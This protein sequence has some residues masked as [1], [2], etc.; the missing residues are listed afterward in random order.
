MAWRDTYTYKGYLYVD[1]PAVVFAAR[2]NQASFTFPLV[3]LTYDGVATGAIA[4]ALPG[5]TLLVGS[6]A[7]ADDLGRVR[8]RKAGSATKIYIGEASQGTLDGEMNPTDDAYL[9]VIAERRVWAVEPYINP[10]TK[11]Y[12]KDYEIPVIDGGRNY[13]QYPGPLA[14]GG[15]DRIGVISSGASY[16]F[17]FNSGYSMAVSSGSTLSGVT[18]DVGDGT[19]VAGDNAT[20]AVI[21]AD[22]PKGRRYV[23][24]TATDSNGHTHTHYILTVVLDPTDANWT[25]IY[26][27][28]IKERRLS[29][30]GPTLTVTVYESLLPATYPEGASVFYWENEAYDG[31]AGSLAG[32][33]TCEH[34]KFRGWINSEA[35]NPV[36]TPNGVVPA[37]ELRCVSTIERMRRIN[38]LPQRVEDNA[39][40]TKWW[41]LTGPTHFGFLYYL[42]RWHSTVLEVAPPSF[43]NAD[44]DY[45]SMAKTTASNLY[46]QIAEFAKASRH[47]LTCDQRGILYWADYQ[48]LIPVASRTA[49]VIET[50]TADD[51]Y[52]VS[53]ERDRPPEVYWLD[54]KGIT[55]LDNNPV[56]CISPGSA[57]GQGA[58]RVE[59]AGQYVA[60]QTELNVTTGHEY[61]RINSPWL[62][63]RVKVVHPGDIGID[64]AYQF[65]VQLTLPA[66]TNTR[67]YSFTNQRCQV[68]EVTIRQPSDGRN[69]K[70]V[71]IALI[72]ETVGTPAQTVVPETGAV[73]PS[74]TPPSSY[75]PIT[76]YNP[77]GGI[78]SLY[79]HKGVKKIAG[80]NTDGYVYITNDFGAVN[81]VWTRYDLGL[82][83]NSHGLKL[84]DFVV[85][86]FSP[87]YRGTGS[88]ING[89]IAGAKVIA[90]IDDIFGART[91]TTQFNFPTEIPA[92]PYPGPDWRTIDASFGFQNWAMC[93]TRYD[94]GAGGKQG[95]YLAYTT[96]GTNWQTEQH[97]G[98]YTENPGANGADTGLYISSKTAGRAYA[99]G[100]YAAGG[101]GGMFRPTKGYVTTDY[102]ANWAAIVAGST[103][104]DLVGDQ[105][106]NISVPWENNV[107]ELL[108]YWSYLN[109]SSPYTDKTF[110][111]ESDG[112][113]VTEITPTISGHGYR[114]R[115]KGKWAIFA[116]PENRQI[117]A[118]SGCYSN[119]L[120]TALFVSSNGGD[121][122]D[123]VPGSAVSGAIA[124]WGVC[125]SAVD[126]LYAWGASGRIS[127]SQNPTVELLDKRGNIPTDY[128]GALDF[129]AIA[130][131]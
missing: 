37:I 98:G 123:V 105:W 20:D 100:Q 56:F 60:D 79:L 112:T 95:A 91:V 23:K 81:P 21:E 120:D 83:A 111:T 69:I 76:N 68:G 50:L 118:M 3:E 16:R 58:V 12:Y 41:H 65:W 87:G 57:P 124:W 96:D 25:P 62:P 6:S 26:D 86:P 51:Y 82:T 1:H 77:G 14:N 75:Y 122:W 80:F 102:G 9:T 54:G 39:S 121:T 130:G 101:T 73:I 94:E 13:G 24:L 129:V 127:Y 99:L 116:C 106:G 43:L 104:P 63:I 17:T 35:A 55:N 34:I 2:V 40:P 5:Y 85:D 15:C 53:I 10:T 84:Y 38:L 89:W 7:G 48:Q 90:R 28:E 61:A 74:Y 113:T 103:G 71:E 66:S 72:V 4:A 31:V 44:D 109:G 33:A 126:V 78:A 18:W 117:I 8:V 70:E 131:G 108:A 11:V 47:K 29:D 107:N 128:P 36:A 115:G 114:P 22:F 64:P 125:R 110:R 97:I 46:Q 42:L 27:F 45:L 19:L 93:V 49:T 92:G 52:E 88:E 59:F 30:Q 119:A 32:P 67:G